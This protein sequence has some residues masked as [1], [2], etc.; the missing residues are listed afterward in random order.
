VPSRGN[1]GEVP[2]ATAA[3]T[4]RVANSVASKGPTALSLLKSISYRVREWPP[5][6]RDQIDSNL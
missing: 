6:T 2:A 5:A 3:E 1:K 4:R